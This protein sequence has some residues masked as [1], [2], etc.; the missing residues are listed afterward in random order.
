MTRMIRLRTECPEIGWGDWELVGTRSPHVL[1]IRYEWRGTSLL[2][3]HNF[4]EHPHD[5]TI[6]LRAGDDPRLVNLIDEETTEAGPGGAYRLSL[7]ALGY[8]WYAVGRPDAAPHR[9]VG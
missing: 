2:C 8:R 5:V 6:R 7:D 9:R 1:A 3:V 4:D